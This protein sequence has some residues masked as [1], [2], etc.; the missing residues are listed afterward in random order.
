MIDCSFC[1]L[2]IFLIGRQ[3]PEGVVCPGVLNK[4]I[5]TPSTKTNRGLEGEEGG[6]KQNTVSMFE[7]NG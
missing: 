4:K 7:Q 3:N 6:R 2:K 1:F 5:V